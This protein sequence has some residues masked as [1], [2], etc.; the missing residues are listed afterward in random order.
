[1]ISNLFELEKIKDLGEYD[2]FIKLKLKNFYQ[3]DSNLEML[4]ETLV[5]CNSLRSRNCICYMSLYR[6][7]SSIK[8]YQVSA[9]RYLKNS[10]SSFIAEKIAADMYSSMES[11]FGSPK[12]DFIV[13]VPCGHSGEQQ[14]LSA[15]LAIELSKMMRKPV[16]FALSQIAQTGSSHPKANICHPPMKLD[17]PLNGSVLLVDDV[18]TS[19]RHLEEA[20]LLLRSPQTSVF[21]VAW[22]GG[23]GE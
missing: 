18:A 21:A 19:G 22:I 3:Q 15:K 14:C 20:S 2:P 16:K 10:D 12:F 1:M 11:L 13:P 4:S 17:F 6:W 5:R 7:R 23:N 8:K 9:L